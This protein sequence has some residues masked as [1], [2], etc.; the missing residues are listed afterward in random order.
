L[1]CAA[2]SAYFWFITIVISFA[3][4]TLLDFNRT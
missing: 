3:Y 4:I 2:K 1:S